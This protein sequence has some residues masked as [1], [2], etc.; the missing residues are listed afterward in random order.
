MIMLVDLILSQMS[1]YIKH[2]DNSGKNMSFM[3]E[4]HNGLVI[5]KDIWNRI[6]DILNMNMKFHSKPFYD[7]KYIKSKI[8]A[9]NGVVNKIFWN[10]KFPE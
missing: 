2:F 6:R 5:Y 9:F 3:I 4:D 10:E 1:E 8:K 7:E